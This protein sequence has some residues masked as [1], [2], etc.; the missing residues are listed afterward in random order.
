MTHNVTIIM[1]T[2]TMVLITMPTSEIQSQS[3]SL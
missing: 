3:L 2:V 1:I